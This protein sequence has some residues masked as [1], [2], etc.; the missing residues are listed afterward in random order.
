MS[1]QIGITKEFRE[2]MQRMDGQV[3]A[4]ILEVMS[5]VLGGNPSVRV[6]ALKACEYVAFAGSR[7]VLRVICLREDG[8]LLLVHVDAHDSAYS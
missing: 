7:N 1:G 5:K 6:H 8:A 3:Q 4:E 2:R